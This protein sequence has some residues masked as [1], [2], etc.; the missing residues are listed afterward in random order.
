K[1]RPALSQ[2]CYKCHSAEAAK[3]KGGLLL[4]TRDGLRA[5]GESGPA[6]VPGEPDK[7]L[8]VK[9]IRHK[10]ENLKMPPKEKL[11]DAVIADLEKWVA[12]GA[13]DPRDGVA[14]LP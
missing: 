5:G 3:L 1:I 14:K 10:D 8:L 2:Y 6:L 9:A 12:M 11:P 7:S 4:D 13:P